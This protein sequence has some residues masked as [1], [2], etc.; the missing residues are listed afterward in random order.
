MH[1][2]V[3]QQRPAADAPAAAADGATAAPL[4][5][6][7]VRFTTGYARGAALSEPYSGVNVLLVGQGGRAVLQRVSP[8]N[9]P[10]H[11]AHQMQA[12]CQVRCGE[13]RKKAEAPNCTHAITHATT[14]M[15]ANTDALLCMDTM[16]VPAVMAGSLKVTDRG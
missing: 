6:Y 13:S 15:L 11:A 9:D 4:T 5:V 16:C 3:Q 8:V 10:A 7:C 2:C 12:I 14:P 1:A